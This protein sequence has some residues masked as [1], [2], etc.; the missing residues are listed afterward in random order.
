MKRIF[1]VLGAIFSFAASAQAIVNTELSSAIDDSWVNTGTQTTINTGTQT[2]VDKTVAQICSIYFDTMSECTSARA[3]DTSGRTLTACTYTAGAGY[4]WCVISSA[5]SG[6]STTEC[7]YS[8]SAACKAVA[9][10][11]TCTKDTSTGC[12]YPISC[13]SGYYQNTELT[14]T[15]N[16]TSKA[17]P[18]CMQCP[19]NGTCN[20]TGV[21]CNS[22]YTL[23]STN[24][25]TTL[26]LR[27][28]K[29]CV[30]ASNDSGDSTAS[31]TSDTDTVS[32][33]CPSGLSKSA[34]GCCC[35]K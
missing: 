7:A 35:I 28:T 24:P 1:C 30:P 21:T 12:Y 2:T 20:G 33:S 5:N 11:G 6:L 17:V 3:Q 22:G 9:G 13:S 15:F 25:G 29:W 31:D 27:G 18:T 26:A 16:G 32:G 4:Q 10:H 8:T 23:T 34:D 19:E 14:I